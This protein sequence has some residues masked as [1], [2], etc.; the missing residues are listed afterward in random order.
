MARGRM[1]HLEQVVEITV[2]TFGAVHYF[3]FTLSGVLRR[4]DVQT[5]AFSDVAEV[6]SSSL[7]R[8]HSA[9]YDQLVNVAKEYPD[10]EFMSP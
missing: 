6:D 10:I 4:L 1:L 5:D 9:T 7:A 2:K 3:Y 8:E